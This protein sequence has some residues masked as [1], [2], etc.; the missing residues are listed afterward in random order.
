MREHERTRN[1]FDFAIDYFTPLR[2]IVVTA[3]ADI[4]NRSDDVLG[5]L[6]AAP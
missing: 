2:V 6:R 1:H 4:H 3:P 5:Q